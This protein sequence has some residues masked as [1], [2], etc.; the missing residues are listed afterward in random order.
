MHARERA[1]LVVLLALLSGCGR[2]GHQVVEM[3]GFEFQPA[4]LAAQ[5]GDTI[6]FVNR[7]GVP[8]TATASDGSWDSGRLDAD[9]SWQWVATERGA[10]S[11]TCAL[12]PS[13]N[14]RIDVR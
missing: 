2:G 8:H 5:V 14:G 12:H 9:S 1:G 10:V 11:Y 4:Y 6:E 3:A 7:D 13:M